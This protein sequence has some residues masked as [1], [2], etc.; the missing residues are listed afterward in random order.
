[1]AGPTILRSD[2]RITSS[3]CANLA[4][5]SYRIGIESPTHRTALTF[6]EVVVVVVHYLV[7]LP[8]PPSH[9]SLSGL[10]LQPALVGWA[11]PRRWGV[12]GMRL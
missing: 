9:H 6:S 10:H 4:F 11:P 2:P 8:H 3:T 7:G 1:M 5:A 12:G